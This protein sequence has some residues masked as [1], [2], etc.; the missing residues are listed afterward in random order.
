MPAC[1]VHI[2]EL[3]RLRWFVGRRKKRRRR[4]RRRRR[5]VGDE[6]TSDGLVL[7]LSLCSF[8]E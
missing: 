4:R 3:N 2:V 7:N 8:V 1:D 5:R 6:K